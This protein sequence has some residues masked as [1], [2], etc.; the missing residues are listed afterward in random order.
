MIG[1]GYSRDSPVSPKR[2]CRLE[3]EGFWPPFA[4]T[5]SPM[6][7]FISGIIVV[8]GVVVFYLLPALVASVRKHHHGPAIFTLNLLLGWTVLGWIL[9]LVWA[10]T[11]IPAR[12][13]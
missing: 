11:G 10:F 12:A 1:Y 13:A 9:A 2:S 8:V 6:E 5:E 4:R 3:N 7:D